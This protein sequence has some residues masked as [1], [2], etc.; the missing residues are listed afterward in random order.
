MFSDWRLLHNSGISLHVFPIA[1]ATRFFAFSLC[2]CDALLPFLTCMTR[3][4]YWAHRSMYLHDHRLG[5][6]KECSQVSELLEKQGENSCLQSSCSCWLLPLCFLQFQ[7]FF[8]SLEGCN[9]LHL[10]S[11]HFWNVVVQDQCFPSSLVHG[12]K[13]ISEFALLEFSS[14]SGLLQS[15]C[16]PV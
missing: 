11:S 9:L 15:P 1:A 3:Q 13:R 7:Q 12:I 16:R 4:C 2:W 6:T 8:T 10:Y 5:Q 14:F